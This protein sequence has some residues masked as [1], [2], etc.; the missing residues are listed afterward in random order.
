MTRY[1]VRFTVDFLQAWQRAGVNILTG[2]IFTKEQTKVVEEAAAIAYKG[3][4]LRK[5][6]RVVSAPRYV[7]VTFVVDVYKKPPKRW[8]R[9]VPK[10]LKPNLPF[11]TT[12]DTD[13]ISK[14]KDGLNGIAWYD[15]AQVVDDHV[16]KHDRLE[17][18]ET[19]MEFTVS[20]EVP[21]EVRPC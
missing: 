4:S 5:Y 20:W 12:P 19:R 11:V 2:A 3:V 18:T 10:W 1:E 14:V 6:G 15:D 16:I 7:P 21:E 9:G 13:N 17:G 8:P